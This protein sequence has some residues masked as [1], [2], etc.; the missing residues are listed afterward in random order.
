MSQLAWCDDLDTLTKH[1]YWVG[2]AVPDGNRLEPFETAIRQAQ[3]DLHSSALTSHNGVTPPQNKKPPFASTVAMYGGHEGRL[4]V[5]ELPVYISCPIRDVAAVL[6][7]R[8]RLVHLRGGRR[9]E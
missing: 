4:E 2:E 1:H 5:I 6:D 3:P 7:H 9:H 8:L